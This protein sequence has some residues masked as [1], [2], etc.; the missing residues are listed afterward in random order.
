MRRIQM[1]KHHS[2]RDDPAPVLSL[3]PRDPDV[4]RAKRLRDR[5]AAAKQSR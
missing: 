1:S 5:A 2:R 3:D 4:L